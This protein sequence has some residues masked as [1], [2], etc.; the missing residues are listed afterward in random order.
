MYP[1]QRLGLVRII[2]GTRVNLEAKNQS[3]IFIIMK[4]FLHSFIFAGS[5]IVHCLR[6]EPNFKIHIAAAIVATTLG[7][8]FRLERAEWLVIII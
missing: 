3:S 1:D 5:G 6:H 2:K 4:R 7:F 8:F